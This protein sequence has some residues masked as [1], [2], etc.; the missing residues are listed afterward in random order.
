MLNKEDI[1]G[2]LSADISINGTSKSLRSF[3][4]EIKGSIDSLEFNDF[5][6]YF[7]LLRQ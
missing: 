5:I 2:K 4:A 6:L 1:L 7:K 3:D